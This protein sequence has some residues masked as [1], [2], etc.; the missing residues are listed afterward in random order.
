[1]SD[2]DHTRTAIVTGASRGIGRAIAGKLGQAGF[3]VAINYNANVDAAEEAAAMVRESGGE[4][5]IVQA[6]I[7]SEDDRARLVDQVV[8]KCG[9][10]DLLVNNAGVAPKVRADML[11]MPED[12]FDYVLGTNLKGPYFLTQR[13]ANHMIEKR[14]AYPEQTPPAIV[15]ITSISSYTASVNRAEYCLAKAGLTMMTKLFAVRLAEHGINVHEVSPGI[16]QTDMT[17][18]VKEKYDRLIIEEGLTP[19]RRWGKPDDI[20]RAVLAVAEG[21]L[22]FSTGEAIHVDGG[23][24]LHWL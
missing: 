22:P 1:M 14:D 2:N 3:M 11:E 21:L 6:D 16:I 13:V 24:H 9:R 15:N 19:I 4:A 12:S 23:F 18:G 5:M 17:S 7:G 10:I 8:H 20:A